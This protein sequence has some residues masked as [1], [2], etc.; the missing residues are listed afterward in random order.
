MNTC[1]MKL[2]NLDPEE[3]DL[4]K[5][6]FRN[7]AHFA[8]N[9]ILQFPEPAPLQ[10]NIADYMQDC[11][12]SED[13]IARGQIQSLRGAGKTWLVGVFVAWLLYCNPNLK[14]AIIC[15]T[16]TYGQRAIGFIR[17]LF[18][19]ELLTTLVPRK[20]IDN[21]FT[22]YKK[23]MTDNAEEFQC[24]AMTLHSSDPSV[25][26]FGLFGTYTGIHPD[27]VIADDI[28]VPE[29]SGTVKK[30][31]KIHEKCKEFESLINPGGMILIL[32]T[33]QTEESIYTE[34]LDS[35]YVARRWPCRY[36]DPTDK[37]ACLNIAP[38]IL[39][40]LRSG[41]A[42]PGD[43]T[44]PERFDDTALMVK[45]SIEGTQ[46]FALQYMLDTSL[47]DADRYPLKLAN[48]I[49]FDSSYDMAP[50]Q[51]V[52]GSQKPVTWLDSVG[53]LGDRFYEAAWASDEF[54]PYQMSMM[55]IDPAGRGNDSV[56]YAVAKALNG[57]VYI[58]DA[59]GF[60][61]KK[62][63]DGASDVVLEK[64]AKIAY[65]NGIKQVI[66]EKNFGDGMYA[67]LLAPIMARICGPVE[68]TEVNSTGQ[69]ELRII[70]VLQPLTQSKKL[71]VSKTVAKNDI[72]WKQYS[73]ITRVRGCLANDDYV[74]ALAGACTAVSA[75]VQ[76]DPVKA[77]EQRKS[78][79]KRQMALDFQQSIER[80]ITKEG[81]R[82]FMGR[83]PT[84][85]EQLEERDRINRTRN[86]R[87]SWGNN[88]RG[89][90]GWGQQ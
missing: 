80:G 47:A 53:L 58:P 55:Y 16:V 28:E 4:L 21:K 85:E 72:L 90:R 32:G 48:L 26:G 22:Q 40:N 66:V 46:M 20:A 12:V 14:I 27:I 6:D 82:V 13:G 69:K 3:T 51:V 73:R 34:K 44:Y 37:P 1:L 60:A 81:H 64:L 15:S 76:I 29:N 30:R 45:E 89:T 18:M 68:I 9:K 63:L 56:A 84:L 50:S 49:V 79:A 10:Y 88:N 31:E 39:E 5:L 87:M 70:D 23:D 42:Q 54:L 62:G 59:G 43:V 77:D 33:P 74:E 7:F 35:R 36:P 61:G 11:P 67:K 71:I 86:R 17:G 52:W 38:W 83:M 78:A 8:W 57:S 2:I 19:H 24:G 75:V 25:K 65:I 41:K